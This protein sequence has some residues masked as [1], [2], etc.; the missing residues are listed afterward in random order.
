MAIPINNYAEFDKLVQ[1]LWNKTPLFGI[2]LH[3]SRRSHKPVATYLKDSAHWLD[4]LAIQCGIYI[5]FPLRRRS[6]GFVNPSNEIA[7]KF[8]LTSNRLPGIILMTPGNDPQDLPVVISYSYRLLLQT[9]LMW[10][11]W[12]LH[13]QIYFP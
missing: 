10:K 8:G 11:R 5:L 13:L 6:A 9:F 4:E 2:F 12:M 7:K 1:K 3:D